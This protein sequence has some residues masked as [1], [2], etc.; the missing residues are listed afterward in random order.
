MPAFG[1]SAYESQGVVVAEK[2]L[3]M[4]HASP[5]ETNGTLDSRTHDV[6]CER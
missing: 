6:A 4:A 5:L 3:S 2:E 1:L